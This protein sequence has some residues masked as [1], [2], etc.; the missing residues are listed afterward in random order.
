M[1]MKKRTG[2]K[3]RVPGLPFGPK[4]YALFAIGLIL[5]VLGFLL[6]STGDI[7]IAPI[8]LILGYCGFLPAAILLKTKRQGAKAKAS[9]E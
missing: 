2:Q 3:S 9:G 7:T 5:I 4:N 1:S 8:I 6:L